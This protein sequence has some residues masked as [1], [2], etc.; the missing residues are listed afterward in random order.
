MEK[1]VA[2]IGWVH[3]YVLRDTKC[4]SN[5]NCTA[6]LVKS[7]DSL[8]CA[9]SPFCVWCTGIGLYGCSTSAI[10][11][12]L[13]Y[14]FSICFAMS[15]II[16]DTDGQIAY[17]ECDAR[18]AQFAAFLHHIWTVSLWSRS[19]QPLFL[20]VNLIQLKW[21]LS[22]PSYAFLST[23]VMSNLHSICSFCCKSAL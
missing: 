5:R 1:Q 13:Q 15:L 20:I 21:D 6:F 7:W 8:Q 11:L 3:M 10:Q 2:I 4:D 14:V 23:L 18:N 9:L 17:M 22:L 16:T 12:Q 19:W